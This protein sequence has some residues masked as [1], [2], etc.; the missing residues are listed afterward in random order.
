MEWCRHSSEK[1]SIMYILDASVY[2]VGSKAKGGR[3]SVL[4]SG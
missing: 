1:K 4:I 3:K 2:W